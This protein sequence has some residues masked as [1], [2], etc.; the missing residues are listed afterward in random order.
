MKII[1]GGLAILS[2]AI[3]LI[4]ILR[5]MIR[6]KSISSWLQPEGTTKKEKIILGASF[7]LIL[8]FAAAGA[9]TNI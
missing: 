4:T 6:Q 1:F 9:L 3:F 7:V 2:Q 8:V 5:N